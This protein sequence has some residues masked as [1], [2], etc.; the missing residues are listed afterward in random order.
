[1]NIDNKKATL[2]NLS[3]SPSLS[4]SKPLK[5]K[6][7]N[8]NQGMFSK[9]ELYTPKDNNLYN[10][11]NQIETEKEEYGYELDQSY[12]NNLNNN[13]NMVYSSSSL[14]NE[15]SNGENTLNNKNLKKK[16][17]IKTIT[18]INKNENMSPCIIYN[19][20]D[21]SDDNNI[22]NEEIDNE[23]NNPKINFDDISY[24]PKLGSIDG[25]F[26]EYENI[27]SNKNYMINNSNKKNNLNNNINTNINIKNEKNIL[28][29]Y[30]NYS[31][32]Y[33]YM[34]ENEKIKKS[35]IL[36]Q[37]LTTEMKKELENLKLEKDIIQK[38]FDIEKKKLIKEYEA[39]MNDIVIEKHKLYD[40]IENQKKE[41]DNINKI[42]EEKN[43]KIEQL[44]KL[45][46][47]FKIDNGNKNINIEKDDK[48]NNIND[49]NNKKSLIR[50]NKI[51]EENYIKIIDNL[52]QNTKQISNNI[53]SFLNNSSI[54]DD[55]IIV[56]NLKDFISQINT[57]NNGNISLN[58][59]LTTINDFTNII[60]LEIESLL[61]YIKNN[62]IDNKI[63]KNKKIDNNINNNIN[64]LTNSENGQNNLVTSNKNIKNK[65]LFSNN[66][67][68]KIDIRNNRYKNIIK[69][70]EFKDNNKILEKNKYIYNLTNDK[71]NKTVFINMNKNGRLYNYSI[72]KN[73]NLLEKNSVVFKSNTS[74]L[75]KDI[76]LYTSKNEDNKFN[77]NYNKIINRILKKKEKNNE[78]IFNK[79][80]HININSKVEEL[81]DLITNNRYNKIIKVKNKPETGGRYLKNFKNFNIP[82][83]EDTEVNNTVD[84]FSSFN[85]ANENILSLSNNFSSKNKLSEK[86]LKPIY[87]NSSETNTF[88][89]RN[90][91][92]TK[93]PSISNYKTINH[94]KISSLSNNFINK[95]FER[96]KL[97]ELDYIKTD[98]KNND[99]Y[100]KINNIFQKINNSFMK[101]Q[102]IESQES[103]K[104]I[105][106]SP[107][108]LG[109]KSFS[110]LHN[111]NKYIKITRNENK[112]N[113]LPQNIFNEQKDKNQNTYDING[114]ANEVMKPSFLK[115]T[116]ILTLN[117]IKSE[118]EKEKNRIKDFKRN[119]INN[120]LQKFEY[121]KTE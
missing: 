36:Q 118:N 7:I 17:E 45:V 23:W 69:L 26:S 92:F 89:N 86:L 116:G 46:E 27:L 2:N 66:L 58:D 75:N 40:I 25:N 28:S 30:R 67:F 65:K 61:K 18:K 59:K 84:I 21:F 37:V 110:S 3:I 120:Y 43:I 97:R 49:E 42:C 91:N 121:G 55:K 19:N 52:Y 15:K 62:I 105:D 93:I 78:N 4:S 35:F 112:R 13:K 90:F 72:K 44:N 103:F 106:V 31:E 104:N 113:Q 5:I 115:N 41:M 87:K 20:S 98:C 96:N 29:N 107:I 77:L 60:K 33:H 47:K 64:N 83:W 48:C 82:V 114:L 94:K 73:N 10:F 63:N 34:P 76:F 22:N 32:Y 95:D 39:K 74:P 100:I 68:K 101:S 80:N 1:M 109:S 8:K 119:N 57:E 11:K 81:S 88:K 12:D 54:N 24:V 53:K 51:I 50:E 56:T 111:K 102:T 14:I 117:N 70:N 79:T 71:S 9:Y 99:D 38:N 108:N 6:S 16:K 85:K